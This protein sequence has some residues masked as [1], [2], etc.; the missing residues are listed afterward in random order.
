MGRTNGILWRQMEGMTV[1]ENVC[2]CNFSSTCKGLND[3]SPFQ[4]CISSVGDVQSFILEEFCISQIKEA[5]KRR[6][7][8][9]QLVKS[10]L[11]HF[12]GSEWVLILGRERGEVFLDVQQI[13]YFHFQDEVIIA[14]M[15]YIFKR[16]FQ[17]IWEI[18]WG[19][20]PHASSQ[21]HQFH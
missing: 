3:W 11:H 19:A 4:Q 5:P 18:I 1:C 13:Y 16:S 9:L 6:L 12:D 20:V 10:S 14:N 8:C 21:G 2:L 7:K 15:K 17:V